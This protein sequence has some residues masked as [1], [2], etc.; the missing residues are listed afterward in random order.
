M[1]ASDMSLP[2][3]DRKPFKRAERLFCESCG[4]VIDIRRHD[5]KFSHFSS[6]KKHCYVCEDIFAA[7]ISRAHRQIRKFIAAG[8][9]VSHEGKSC[10]DCGAPAVFYDIR[11]YSKPTEVVPICKSCNNLR[12]PGILGEIYEVRTIM[13]FYGSLE[14]YSPKMRPVR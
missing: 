2:A 8:S 11:N 5:G 14:T 12:G 4:R 6:S 7:A 3:L 10:A 1:A 9:M 13:P